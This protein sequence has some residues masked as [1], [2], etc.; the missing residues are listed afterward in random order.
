MHNIFLMQVVL[1]LFGWVFCFVTG[2]S[3]LQ[4]SHNLC[5]AY[6]PD[7]ANYCPYPTPLLLCAPV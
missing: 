6:Y 1:A 5:W 7:G 4:A 2:F 3:K